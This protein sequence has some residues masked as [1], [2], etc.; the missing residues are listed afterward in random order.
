MKYD[1]PFE[2]LQKYSPVTYHLH[3]PS[4]YG[5]HPVLNASHLEAY[6]KSDLAFGECP[7]KH[8]NCVDF[9]E[10]PEFDVE[11]I[12]VERWH[13]AHNRWRVQELLTCFEGYDATYD[14]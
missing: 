2:I 11:R 4:S 6:H 9:T 3:L 13:K 14:E 10:M 8:L 1:G 5:M 7:H 12:I